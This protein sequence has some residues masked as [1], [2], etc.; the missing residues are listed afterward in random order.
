MKK[1]LAILLAL[2]L[3]LSLS[4]CRSSRNPNPAEGVYKATRGER[5]GVSVKVDEILKD[6][7]S[8]ELQDNGKAI[9]RI[10][11]QEFN[12]KWALED[13][14]LT[15]AASDSTYYGTLSKGV[16]KLDNILNSGVNITF[17]KVN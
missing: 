16:I 4:A 5:D 13:T 11:E 10:G 17:E 7:W 9:L 6:Q 2:T 14:T 8:I 15:L 1:T 3:L 12:L